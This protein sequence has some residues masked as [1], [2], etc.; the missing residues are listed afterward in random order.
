MP[1][2]SVLIECREEHKFN[3]E[4]VDC[5]VRAHMVNM[6][7]FDVHL[8]QMMDSGH[9]YMAVAFVMQLVQR[10]V[11]RLATARCALADDRCD[12]T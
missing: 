4:A 1:C 9:N 8:A 12:V 6:Q 5:L 3:I 2:C 11:S 10:S 7:Q